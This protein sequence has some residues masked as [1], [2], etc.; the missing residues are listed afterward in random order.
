MLQC[1]PLVSYAPNEL[2]C[3]ADRAA[4]AG[5]ALVLSRIKYKRWYSTALLQNKPVLAPCASNVLHELEL[6]YRTKRVDR[7]H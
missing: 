3:L 1:T 7:Q 6:A 2:I 4:N 5:C